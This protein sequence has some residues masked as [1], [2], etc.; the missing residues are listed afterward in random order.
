MTASPRPAPASSS[1]VP[2]TVWLP[3]PDQHPETDARPGAL[4]LDR[5]VDKIPGKMLP[6]IAAHAIRTTSAGP[7]AAGT[8]SP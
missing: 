5:A 1:L 6:A 2:T 4:L 8:T 7:A 3:V